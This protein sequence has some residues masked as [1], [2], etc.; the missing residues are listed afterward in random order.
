MVFKAVQLY[1]ASDIASSVVTLASSVQALNSDLWPTVAAV[2][3]Y[4]YQPFGT[5]W[6]NAWCSSS[7]LAQRVV[8]KLGEDIEVSQGD[9]SLLGD[10]IQSTDVTNDGFQS[11]DPGAETMFMDIVLKLPEETED[12]DRIANAD[13]RLRWLLDENWRGRRKGVSRYV[14]NLGDHTVG[15]EIRMRWIRWL[16]PANAKELWSRWMVAYTRS[17]PR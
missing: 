12:W 4:A 9:I 16:V 1:I 2:P 14:P 6:I 10:E 13:I 17:V 8:F 11:N 3:S 7:Q 15:S 5:I